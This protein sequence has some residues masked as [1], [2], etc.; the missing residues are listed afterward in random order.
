MFKNLLGTQELK[1]ANLLDLNENILLSGINSIGISTVTRA[2]LEVMSEK[3]KLTLHLFSFEIENLGD[4][5]I[6]Q[7]FIY[8]L[9]SL[10][11]IDLDT[12]DDLFTK[13]NFKLIVAVDKVDSFKNKDILLKF[14]EEVRSKS[15]YKI[16]L[17][18]SCSFEFYVKNNIQYGGFHKFL[19][20]GFI[21]KYRELILS[22]SD[23]YNIPKLNI[24]EIKKI[25]SYSGGHTGLTKSILINYKNN[26]KLLSLQEIL[27]NNEDINNRCNL[28]LKDLEYAK[29]TTEDIAHNKSLPKLTELGLA[30]DMKISEVLEYFCKNKLNQNINSFTKTEQK[31]YDFLEGAPYR[32][33]NEIVDLINKE[34][35]EITNWT[36]YKHINNINK[37]LSL[38]NIK[39]KSSRKN[40][41]RIIKN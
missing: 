13:T 14:L 7:Y 10:Y 1:I 23:Y 9:K 24:N 38:S 33:I 21:E 6:E 16:T 11:G 41:Y 25:K 4:K 37:K 30:F 8:K 15:F 36:V 34:D 22:F 17:L 28:I 12:I 19:F 29:I 26:N 40:G 20:K 3:N 5:E 32:S 39:I 27:N 31:I 35:I 2:I 18:I